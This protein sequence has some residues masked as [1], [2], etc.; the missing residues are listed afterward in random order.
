MG[1][2]GDFSKLDKL[3]ATMRTLVSA[4]F[5]AEL[6][7]ELGRT[8]MK[9]IADQFNAERDPYGLP[10]APLSRERARDRRA[11]I[12]AARKGKTP[13]GGKILSNT[14]RMR[15]S[16]NYQATSSGFRV[17]IP[18]EYATFHQQ[19]T[20]HMVKRMLVPTSADGLGPIWLEAFNRSAATMVRTKLKAVA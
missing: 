18:V 10:W 7:D 12:S 15:G 5:K 3:R 4:G 20:V 8:S 6:S 13:R 2:T 17:S 16:V 1:V 19:G 9:L 14:G 11:R